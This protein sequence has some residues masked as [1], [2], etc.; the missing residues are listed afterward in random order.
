MMP[1]RRA[2]RTDQTSDDSCCGGL[3]HG[4][5]CVAVV[6]DDRGCRQGLAR[7]RTRHSDESATGGLQAQSR[8][9]PL[10]TRCDCAVPAVVCW[11]VLGFWLKAKWEFSTAGKLRAMNVL[12]NHLFQAMPPRRNAGAFTFIRRFQPF[13]LLPLGGTFNFLPSSPARACATAICHACFLIHN[14]KNIVFDINLPRR[15]AAT[16]ERMKARNYLSTSRPLKR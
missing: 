14:E 3:L 16:A 13:S 11:S 7:R 5:R 12:V 1:A 6:L 4:R 8:S 2:A 9:I 15:S 10:C